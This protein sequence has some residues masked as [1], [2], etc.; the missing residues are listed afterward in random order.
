MKR[1]L[2]WLIPLL[3]VFVVLFGVLLVF[4][5]GGGE[6]RAR[7]ISEAK[8]PKAV[9]RPSEP[10]DNGDWDEYEKKYDKWWDEQ[11]ERRKYHGSG[12]NLDGFV[13]KTASAFLEDGKENRVYSPISVYMAL[14]MLAEVTDGATRAEILSLLGSE[15]IAALRERANAVW[16]ANYSDDGITKCVLGNSLWLSDDITYKKDTL[17]TLAKQYYASSFYGEMGTKEYNKL[18]RNWLNDQTGGL[19]AKQV[20]NEKLSAYTVAAI[21]STI[22]FKTPW[23]E[24]FNENQTKEDVFHA[25]T[26]D[27]RCDFLNGEEVERYVEGEKFSATSRGLEGNGNMWFI[28]PNEGISTDELL[29]DSEAL[30]FISAPNDYE[31][32]EYASVLLSVPKFDVNSRLDLIAGLKNLGVNACFDDAK[33][34]FTPLT[35]LDSLYVS[36][37]DHAARVKINEDGVEGAAYT[38]MAVEYTSVLAESKKIEFKADRPFIFVV[39]GA[40]GLPLFIGTVN[41]VK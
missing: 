22:Y 28:L 17:S 2:K 36:R 24:E 6:I 20:K 18:F 7:A 30:S 26:G 12:K 32:V 33:S 40:D 39:T 23:T 29:T 35:D 38:V 27:K 14:S 37:A 16:N 41:E 11:I 34:D 31:D 13:S 4:R 9:Q 8:Y 1:K 19:L 25:S 21:A 5:D 3:T 10:T 15:D